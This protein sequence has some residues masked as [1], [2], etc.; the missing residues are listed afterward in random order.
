MLYFVTAARGTEDF[1][2]DE[3]NCK[4][5]PTRIHKTDGKVFFEMNT[6][7]SCSLESLFNLKSVERLFVA[8]THNP[9]FRIFGKG[10]VYHFEKALA[11]IDTWDLCLETWRSCHPSQLNR[12][13]DAA[14][15]HPRHQ[16][17]KEDAEMLKEDTEDVPGK[18]R[19]LDEEQDEDGEVFQPTFRVSC[20]CS[21]SAAR[22][23]TPQHLSK[24][25]SYQ[26]RTHT[27]WKVDLRRPLFEVTVQLNNA[28]LTIGLPLCDR[29]LS[30][31]PYIKT[32]G[33]RSTLAWILSQ[34][35][36]VKPGDIVLDP[37]CGAGTILV[38]AA[39]SL[40]DAIY[41]GSDIS[42]KQLTLAMENVTLAKVCGNVHLFQA[43]VKQLPQL[44]GQREVDCIICDVPFG[45]SHS[46][47]QDVKELYPH[48]IH[49]MDSV[50]AVHGR[51]VLLTSTDLKDFLLKQV[52]LMNASPCFFIKSG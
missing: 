30:Q 10:G 19:K 45:I 13:K 37:M 24:V 39:R 47:V 23:F 6:S 50:L 51:V 49:A 20:K 25:V 8:A 15:A 26:L 3:L 1:V 27:G 9:D 12:T 28:G 17:Q 2:V 32:I 41:L 21:G 5:Q 18:R 22:F 46:C 14:T 40:P 38:E 11:S 44:L 7:D 31:R 42:D 35:A 33:L 43:D 34:L 16:L 48:L 29:P 4:C 36:K 52:E